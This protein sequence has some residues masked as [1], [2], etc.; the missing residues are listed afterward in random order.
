[1]H[2]QALAHLG[3]ACAA[4]T[5]SSGSAFAPVLELPAA[6]RQA[7]PGVP[8]WLPPSTLSGQRPYSS[9]NTPS[10]SPTSESTQTASSSSGGASSRS[11]PS[12]TLQTKEWRSWI[13]TKLDS[14]LEGA[15][16]S[17]QGPYRLLGRKAAAA[18][19]VAVACHYAACALLAHNV[20][21]HAFMSLCTAMALCAIQHDVAF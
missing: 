7:V 2:R 21:V 16:S 8:A 18:A 1:M 20:P 11:R 3:R 6:L 10:D 13:D 15:G 17:Q 9:S 12:R 14:K 19:T 5:S 4:T